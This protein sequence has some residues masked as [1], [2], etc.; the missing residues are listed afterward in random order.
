[1]KVEQPPEL[2]KESTLKAYIK[3]IQCEAGGASLK[4][5][6]TANVKYPAAV[7]MSN[8]SNLDEL[9]LFI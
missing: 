2:E 3:S 9:K 4:L 8:T 5:E 6:Q 1:L 7:L